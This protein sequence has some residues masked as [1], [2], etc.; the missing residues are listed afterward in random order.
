MLEAFPG[1][2]FERQ[3]TPRPCIPEP[4]RLIGHPLWLLNK[5]RWSHPVACAAPPPSPALTGEAMTL[6]QAY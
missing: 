5:R 2:V 6:S 3:G 4:S 1:C